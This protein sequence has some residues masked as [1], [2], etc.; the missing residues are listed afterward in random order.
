M[1]EA[2]HPRHDIVPIKD[3]LDA[4]I[5]ALLLLLDTIDRKNTEIREIIDRKNGEA[6][7]TA[8]ASE[9]LA[10]TVALTEI[11]GMMSFH[12]DLIRKGERDTAESKATYM[13]WA[14]ARAVLLTVVA[15][16]TL[17]I[18]YVSLV[19]A[20]GPAPLVAQSGRVDIPL[21]LADDQG[22]RGP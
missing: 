18:A 6:I 2:D 16:A 14:S 5:A 9:Q 4:R 7:A 1:S 22:G 12:N 8:L 19:P 3:L 21:A 10:R 17:A 11:K 15:I 20:A 13:T